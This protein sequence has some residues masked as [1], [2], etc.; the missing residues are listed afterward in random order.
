MTHL[1]AVLEGTRNPQVVAA[2]RAV[3]GLLG[4]DTEQL[5]VGPGST[6]DRTRRVLGA[7][8]AEDVV[9]AAV[10]AGAAVC[11]GVITHVAVPVV[12]I[13]REGVRSMR[14]ISRVLL[15]LDGSAEAALGVADLARRAVDTDADVTAVHVFDASTVPA[16]WDQAAHSYRAWTREFQHRYLP[17]SV[18]LDL[19]RG[20]PADQVLAAAERA[21]VDLIVLGWNQRLDEGRAAIVRQAFTGGRVPVLLVPTGARTSSRT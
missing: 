4:V 18:H 8:A 11:E 13:P 7:L 14:G 16:F 2:A 19:R 6:A 17:E 15:P 12:V 20:L 3:A 1:T 9:A 10:S 5:Q 21:G